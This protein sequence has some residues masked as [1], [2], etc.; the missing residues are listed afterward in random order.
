MLLQERFFLLGLGLVDGVLDGLLDLLEELLEGSL[1]LGEDLVDHVLLE[2][3]ERA[4]DEEEVGEEPDK[5]AEGV[6]VGKDSK[7]AE[8]EEALDGHADILDEDDVEDSLEEDVDKVTGKV[9]SLLDPVAGDLDLLS[10]GGDGVLDLLLGDVLTVG[11]GAVADGEAEDGGDEDEV[12]EEGEESVL[13]LDDGVSEDVED[14]EG[15]NREDD[16]LPVED[17]AELLS[18]LALA[19]TSEG[20]VALAGLQIALLLLNNGSGSSFFRHFV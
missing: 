9:G 8:G 15:K 13:E 18:N 19:K 16:V 20:A 17:L 10:I 11:N 14:H 7:E 4:P 2:V 3:I 6:A 12:D 5:T 1:D